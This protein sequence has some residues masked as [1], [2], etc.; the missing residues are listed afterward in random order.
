[1]AGNKT[2]GRPEYTPTDDE[3]EKVRVLKASGM[4]QEAIAEAI[5]IS[6]PTLAKHFT[7]ELDRGTAKVKP[8]STLAQKCVGPVDL[9]DKELT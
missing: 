4:S 7:S 3:R 8:D 1:M 6:V 2:S 9:D 5:G